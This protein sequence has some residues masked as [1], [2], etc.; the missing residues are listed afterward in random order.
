MYKQYIENNYKKMGNIV[1]KNKKEKEKQ[2][3]HILK[4]FKYENVEKHNEHMDDVLNKYRHKICGGYYDGDFYHFCGIGN[5]YNAQNRN[6]VDE[7][8]KSNNINKCV[9]YVLSNNKYLIYDG[10][11]K[12]T[13]Y[14]DKKNNITR[15]LTNDTI[16]ELNVINTIKAFDHVVYSEENNMLI[17]DMYNVMICYETDKDEYY[18]IRKTIIQN[19]TKPLFAIEGKVYCVYKNTQLF[20]TLQISSFNISDIR[21]GKVQHKQCEIFKNVILITEK[22]GYIYCLDEMYVLRK[23]NRE[24]SVVAQIE[25]LK[26]KSNVV[27]FF[28]LNITDN[29]RIKIYYFETEPLDRIKYA[30]EM[31]FAPEGYNYCMTELSE[32]CMKDG[33]LLTQNTISDNILYKKQYYKIYNEQCYFVRM[34]LSRVKHDMLRDYSILIPKDIINNILFYL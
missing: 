10:Y 6:N 2:Q 26:N 1:H 33:A 31:V 17:I 11:N 3:L 14:F 28:A 29:N 21:E 27:Y 23:Y 20:K 22:D 5:D 8:I 12:I 30:M 34:I 19:Y 18:V 24:L 9:Y 25:F 15:E 16:K 7:C 32:Y 4:T 13:I